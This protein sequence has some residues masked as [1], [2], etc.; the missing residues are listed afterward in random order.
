MKFVVKSTTKCGLLD[1]LCPYTCRG[2]GRLGAV[3][4]ECCKNNLIKAAL[5]VCP[6]CQQVL[7]DAEKSCATWKN[8]KCGNCKIAFDALFV[9]GWREGVLAKLVKEYK[10]QAVRAIGDVLVE[11][12]DEAILELPENTVVVP[13]PTVGRHVRERGLDHTLSLAKK[14]AR[15]RGWKCQRLLLRASDTVQVGTKASERAEQ[16]RKAYMVQKE[17]DSDVNYLLLDDVWTTGASMLAAEKVMRAAGAKKVMGVVIAV[18]K[19]KEL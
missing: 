8:C 1:L 13:L 6:L 19:Q 9:G 12:L 17:A 3:L 15:K 14:L 18:G 11:V 5:R 16:A 7:A 10:Y 4:C 2:C